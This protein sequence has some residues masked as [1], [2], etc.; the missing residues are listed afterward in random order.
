MSALQLE[1]EQC[2]GAPSRR[3]FLRRGKG[4]GPSSLLPRSRRETHPGALLPDRKA[5]QVLVRPHEQLAVRRGQ[6]GVERLGQV[7]GGEALEGGA[8]GQDEGLALQVTDVEPA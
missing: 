6:G 7:V 5:V 1:W 4:P 2:A 3:P 8:G